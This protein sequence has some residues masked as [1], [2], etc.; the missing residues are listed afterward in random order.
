VADAEADREEEDADAEVKTKLLLPSLLGESSPLADALGSSRMGALIGVRKVGPGL[1]P[2]WLP[3]RATMSS[4]RY[5][6]VMPS[7]HGLEALVLL[8]RSCRDPPRRAEAPLD[9][10]RRSNDDAADAPLD[11]SAEEEPRAALRR[12]SA[13]EGYFRRTTPSTWPWLLLPPPLFNDCATPRF[14]VLESD[15]DG[16]GLAATCATFVLWPS[17]SEAAGAGMDNAEGLPG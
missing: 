16:R 3:P 10:L 8:L 4:I 15:M 17:D 1:P 2:R 9:A 13:G 12:T 11:R 14:D 7:T 5:R 6:S